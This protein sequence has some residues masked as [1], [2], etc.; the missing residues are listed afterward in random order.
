MDRNDGLLADELAAI[1]ATSAVSSARAWQKN[2]TTDADVVRDPRVIVPIFIDSNVIRY[3]AVVGVKVVKVRTEFVAGHEPTVTP[4]SCWTGKM[5]PHDYVLLSEVSAE[6]SLP[7][8]QPP[9][10]RDELRAICDAH[11]SKDDIVKA[12]ES[13]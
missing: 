6:V 8:E 4:I 10:T 3:W 2:W 9:P 7:A 11:T 12:L 13:K 5:V 1:D